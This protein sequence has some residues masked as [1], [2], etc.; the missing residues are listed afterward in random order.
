[1]GL[2][3]DYDGVR[4]QILMQNPLSSVDTAYSMLLQVEKQRRVNQN[5][6]EVFESSA[7]MSKEQNQRKFGNKSEYRK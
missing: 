7:M 6:D 3:A 4:S 1:M 2:N 5:I